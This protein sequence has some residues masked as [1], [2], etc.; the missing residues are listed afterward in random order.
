[1]RRLRA[2]VIASVLAAIPAFADEAQP[3][4][5]VPAPDPAPTPEPE[6]PPPVFKAVVTAIAVEKHKV[7]APALA[8]AGGVSRARLHGAVLIP[9]GA[10]P[11]SVGDAFL[12]TAVDEAGRSLIPE[13]PVPAPPATILFVRTAEGQGRF[14]EFAVELAPPVPGARKLAEAKGAVEVRYAAKKAE[15]RHLLADLKAGQVIR[16]ADGQVR[17]TIRE[18]APERVVVAVDGDIGRIGALGFCRKDGR[19][20]EDTLATAWA[21][22]DHAE[23]TLETAGVAGAKELGLTYEVYEGVATAKVRFEARDLDLP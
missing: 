19:R 16:E 17:L 11:V 4:A 22:A 6:P 18:L 7:Y 21:G 12:E 9:E 3:P 23:H 8:A 2:A 5:P 14:V 1:M 13:T 10:V 15:K 20:H